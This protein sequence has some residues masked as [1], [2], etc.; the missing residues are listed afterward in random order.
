MTS[1]IGSIGWRTFRQCVLNGEAIEDGVTAAYTKDQG[2]LTFMRQ[3][4]EALPF[5]LFVTS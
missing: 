1:H 3:V 4:F 2:T 5:L